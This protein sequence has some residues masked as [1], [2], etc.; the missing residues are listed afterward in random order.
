MQAITTDDGSKERRNQG[1]LYLSKD[2]KR[3]LHIVKVYMRNAMLSNQVST[4]KSAI[5][6]T[7]RSFEEVLQAIS[8][9]VNFILWCIVSGY[10]PSVRTCQSPSSVQKNVYGDMWF[11]RCHPLPVRSQA[12]SESIEAVSKVSESR[13]D[14][15]ESKVND[16][17]PVT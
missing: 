16:G 3:Q 6:I 4:S 10:Q 15:T 13:N 9:S 17:N 12:G 7:S 5:S 14:I 11:D 1:T 8:Q 2:V